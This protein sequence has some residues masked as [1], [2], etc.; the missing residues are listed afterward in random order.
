MEVTSKLEALQEEQG[1]NWRANP[2]MDREVLETKLKAKQDFL[3]MLKEKLQQSEQQKQELT[4]ELEKSMW[5][6]FFVLRYFSDLVF[7]FFVFF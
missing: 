3:N 4:R 6:F 7:F 2:D 1:E 5:C